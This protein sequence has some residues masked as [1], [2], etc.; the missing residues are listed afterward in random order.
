MSDARH[1]H[2]PSILDYKYLR[3]ADFQP[4]EAYSFLVLSRLERAAH[5]WKT[6]AFPYLQSLLNGLANEIKPLATAI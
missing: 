2:R 4:E 5:D 3:P 1:F 6:R